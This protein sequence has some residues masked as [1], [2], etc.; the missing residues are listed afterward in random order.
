MPKEM[1]NASDM[2]T[3]PGSRDGAVPAPLGALRGFAVVTAGLLAAACGAGS[4]SLVHEAPVELRDDYYLALVDDEE[5]PATLPAPDGCTSQLMAG[6]ISFPTS[7]TFRMSFQRSVICSARSSS[8][9]STSEGDV[10]RSGKGLQLSE[11]DSDTTFEGLLSDTLLHIGGMTFVAKGRGPGP[12]SA[13]EIRAGEVQEILEEQSRSFAERAYR[14]DRD[15]RLDEAPALPPTDTAGLGALIEDHFRGWRLTTER[16]IACRFP[17][18]DGSRP[19]VYWGD[20]WG[21]G[22]AWWIWSGDFNGDG[23][24]DRLLLLSREDDPS[25]DLL[26]VVFA[27]DTSAEVTAPGG[28]GIAVGPRKGQELRPFDDF[29]DPIVLATDAISILYWEKASEAYHWRDGRF[30]PVVTSD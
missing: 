3:N 13:E 28:W 10:L 2:L 15:T 12:R 19:E 27:D 1:R 20:R 11:R 22:R 25:R 4:S 8:S 6:S 18:I 30:V 9:A 5:L 17:L 23:R 16:E 14:C 26:A 24:A 29:K 7:A 21:S